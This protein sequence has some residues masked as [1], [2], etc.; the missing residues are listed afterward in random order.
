MKE[1]MIEAYQDRVKTGKMHVV[2]LMTPALIVFCFDEG[3]RLVRIEWEATEPS[4][5]IGYRRGDYDGLVD[6]FEKTEYIDVPKRL[7]YM[8]LGSHHIPVSGA[9]RAH[10]EDE[11]ERYILK[12]DLGPWNWKEVQSKIDEAL[13]RM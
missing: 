7:R 3:E 5:R 11:V 13:Q 1:R 2:S 9:V 8:T 12:E 4:V 6:L 10:M